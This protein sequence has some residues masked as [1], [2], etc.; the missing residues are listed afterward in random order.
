[1]IR[2]ASG[3]RL[4]IRQG[5]RRVLRHAAPTLL[6]A[7]RQ[8]SKLAG[9]RL[10][11][12][13]YGTI[14]PGEAWE[15]DGFVVQPDR[16]RLAFLDN[17]RGL[18]SLYV[19]VFHVFRTPM[20]NLRPPEA[21]APFIHFGHSGVWLFFVIS[22]FSLCLTMSRHVETGHALRSFAMSR[23][24]RIA[25]LF[26]VLIVYQ[27]LYVYFT[28]GWWHDT[29]MVVGSFLFVF[30]MV[31]IWAGSPVSGGWAIGAEMV[32]YAVFPLL[33]FTLRSIPAKISVLILSLGMYFVFRTQFDWLLDDPA[34]WEKYLSRSFLKHFPTFM[35]GMIAFDLY[36]RCRES[37][38]ARPW[39]WTLLVAGS[40][41]AFVQMDN[42]FQTALFDKAHID[43]LAYALIVL[44]AGL[45]QPVLLA[46]RVLSY[47]GRIS[48]SLYL[49]HI[50]VIVVTTPLLRELYEIDAS[51]WLRFGLCAGTVLGLT[52]AL[53]HVSYHVIERPLENFGKG[54]IRRYSQP[55]AQLS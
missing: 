26:Y 52:T 18:A 5:R 30:N 44:G 10:Y 53:A 43:G 35:L 45:C 15:K 6:D 41:L 32:F 28:L 12:A 22:A 19:V 38:D 21:I 24:F 54:L 33:Y 3:I 8:R 17:L 16:V 9:V 36:Q 46:T 4:G 20:P 40:A 13:V 51:I 42:P 1:M 50:Q 47:Y 23:F 7:V 11:P 55:T 48:Y 27:T 25:P 49:W 14:M 34:M 37:T 31:P 29:G 2:P 39:G